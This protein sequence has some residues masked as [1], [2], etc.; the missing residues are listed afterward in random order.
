MVTDVLR[1]LL[2]P[3]REQILVV[4]YPLIAEVI[5][6]E[7]LEKFPN[8]PPWILGLLDWRGVKLPIV[9][10]EMIDETFS[11]YTVTEDAQLVIL[12]RISESSKLDFYGIVLQG[13]PRRSR[14]IRSEFELVST[15][16]EPHLIMEVNL[17]GEQVFIANFQYVQVTV[18]AVPDLLQ[19]AVGK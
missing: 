16:L 10:L 12:N 2:L 9:T 19:E 11:E 6:Y 15:C 8:Q 1:C 3:I 13:V 18:D 4:P 7:K 5:P 17:R 14:Y